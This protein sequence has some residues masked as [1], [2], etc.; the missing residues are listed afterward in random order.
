MPKGHHGQTVSLSPVWHV[1]DL[2]GDRDRPYI[3]YEGRGVSVSLHPQAWENI[4]RRDGSATGEQL[5]TYRLE[6]PN[7]EFYFV[8]PSADLSC[9]RKW[10]LDHHF[11]TERPGYHVSYINHL[12]ETA[13]FCMA[14]EERARAEAE[15]RDGKVEPSSILRLDTRGVTY[16]EEAF[17]QPPLEADPVLIE[18][19]LPVWIARE[20]DYDGVW[21]DERLDPAN[22]SAPRGTIFQAGLESFEISAETR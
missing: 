13:Y 16:W 17:N 12:G 6:K 14:D 5:S 19:L 10:C 20:Q 4:M 21:W 3:S 2:S 1:G 18:G 11:V 22:F 15:A 9:E 8:D 7:A